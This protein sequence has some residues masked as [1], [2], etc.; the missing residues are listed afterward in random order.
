LG[1]PL[2]A[3]QKMFLG[4]TPYAQSFLKKDGLDHKLTLQDVGNFNLYDPVFL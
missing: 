4:F 1:T 2:G 3:D